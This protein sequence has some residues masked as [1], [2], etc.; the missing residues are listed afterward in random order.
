MRVD[1]AMYGGGSALRY[2]FVE[3][4]AQLRNKNEL[5]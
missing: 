5:K 3:A 4:R 2:A 1:E